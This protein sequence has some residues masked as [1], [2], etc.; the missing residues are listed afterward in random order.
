MTQVISKTS[1]SPLTR[2]YYAIGDCCSAPGWKN[3]QGADAEGHG[4][5]IK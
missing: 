5:A 1:E 3:Y 2:S 4:C